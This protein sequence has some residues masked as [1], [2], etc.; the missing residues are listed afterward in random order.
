MPVPI[1]IDFVSDIACP[2]CV[3]GLGGLEQALAKLGDL[4]S[5]DLRFQPFEL[6]PDMPAEGKNIVEQIAQKY[7]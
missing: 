1:K 6:N 5:A 3:V 4:V 7:A 2:W